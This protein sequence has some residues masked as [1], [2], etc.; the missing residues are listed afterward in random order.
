MQKRIREGGREGAL[1]MMS[2]MKFATCQC[3][4]KITL[5]VSVENLTSKYKIMNVFKYY[6]HTIAI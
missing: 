5:K 2:Y 6:N 4:A 3:F 1:M